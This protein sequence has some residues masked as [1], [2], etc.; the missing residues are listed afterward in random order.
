[1]PPCIW[2]LDL[3]SDDEA[4]EGMAEGVVDDIVD[5]THNNPGTN[6]GMV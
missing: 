6:L 4:D 3:V 1:M 5:A 2:R